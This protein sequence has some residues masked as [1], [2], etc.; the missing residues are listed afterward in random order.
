MKE[1]FSV[2]SQKNWKD[3]TYLGDNKPEYI[4]TMTVVKYVVGS[5]DFCPG[6][7]KIP[8]GT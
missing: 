5:L 8:S 2:S 6:V 4:L 7:Y 3:G 1:N